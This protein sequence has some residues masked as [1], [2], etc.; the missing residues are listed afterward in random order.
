MISYSIK[1]KE[2]RKFGIVAF[3]F[4]GAACALGLLLHKWIPLYL[5]G[6]LSLLG[7]AFIFAPKPLRP[8]YSAWRRLAHF[9]GTGITVVILTLAYYAVI[10]PSA[11]MKR[12]LGG[13]PLP[14]RP[15]KK[16]LSYWMVRAEPA[17]PKERFSKRY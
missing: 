11:L 5:F 6:S 15:D 7:L 16:V 12:V 1:T 2:I 4:F 14:L 13:R 10:T 17:Q 8:V 3:L 9:I